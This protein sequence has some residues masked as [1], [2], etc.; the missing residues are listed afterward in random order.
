MIMSF[1]CPGC[2]CTFF[3]NRE[4][5]FVNRSR[6]VFNFGRVGKSPILFGEFVGLGW[7][8]GNKNCFHP[9]GKCQWPLG[10]DVF[11]ISTSCLLRNVQLLTSH[12]WDRLKN[13]QIL[14]HGS[15]AAS[16]SQCGEGATNINFCWWFVF[17]LFFVLSRKRK[18]KQILYHPK[19]TRKHIPTKQRSFWENHR[20]LKSAKVYGRGYVI[21]PRVRSVGNFWWWALIV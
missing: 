21:V 5:I 19:K 17:G 14:Q 2:P 13:R 7:F 15:H 18:K 16:V 6:A 10:D 20:G 4:G 11:I 9:W 1:W 3:H 12:P 8:T